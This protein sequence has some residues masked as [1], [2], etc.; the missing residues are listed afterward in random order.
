MNLSVVRNKLVSFS[1]IDIDKVYLVKAPLN[2]RG[3]EAIKNPMA[4]QLKETL[5]VVARKE[6]TW[7]ESQ[8]MVKSLV[9]S[10]IKPNPTVWH[11][12]I[13]NRLMPTTLN[14]TISVA[15]VML[16]YSIMKGLELNIGSIIREEIL[17]Y[18]RKRAG[19]LFFGLLIT[20]LCQRAKIL[21]GKDEERPFYHPTIDLPLDERLKYFNTQRKDKVSTSQAT[22]P[23]RFIATSPL[24]TASPI[25]GSTSSLEALNFAFKKLDHIEERLTSYWVY[26]KERD[27]AIKEFYLSIAPSI[28]PIFPEFLKD[29]LP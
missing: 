17:S 10:D 19:K 22:P 9:P 6:V 24:P 18:G 7:K 28:D 14:N 2:P 13:K 12:F 1:S 16:L 5:K 21:P 26:A 4:K 25:S 11:H 3:N 15:R 8:T 23:L 29:L 20:Q 27:E